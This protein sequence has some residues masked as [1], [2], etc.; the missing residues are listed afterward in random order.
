LRETIKA[1]ELE[2]ER[3]QMAALS[4]VVEQFCKLPDRS[5]STVRM[6]AEGNLAVYFAGAGLPSDLLGGAPVMRILDE[7]FGR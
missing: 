2:A 7:A 3:L 4:D 5:E 6:T 1:G